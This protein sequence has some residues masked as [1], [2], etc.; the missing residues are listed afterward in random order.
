V[1]YCPPGLLDDVTD[2]LAAVRRWDGVVEKKLGVFYVRREPFLHFHLLATGRR[3][4]DVK[5]SATW[6]QLDLPRPIT[7]A[8]RRALLSEL[9]KRYA[10]KVG[11]ASGTAPLRAR[12]RRA[13]GA[14]GHTGRRPA[15]EPRGAQARM[16]SRRA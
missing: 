15:S 8:R 3:R 4:A 5:G 11:P 13:G 9:R 16:A 14:P 10:E 6:A 12:P 2:V 1:A 7:A